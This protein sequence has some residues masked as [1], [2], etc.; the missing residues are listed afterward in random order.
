MRA[1]RALFRWWL[2]HPWRAFWFTVVAFYA[3][4]FSLVLVAPPPAALTGGPVFVIGVV[5]ILLA[6]AMRGFRSH[7]DVRA[8]ARSSRSACRSCSWS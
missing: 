2:N 1:I 4:L 5:L 7:G 3:G 8:G 6:S